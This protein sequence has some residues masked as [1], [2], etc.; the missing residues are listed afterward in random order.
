MSKRNN[1]PN[2]SNGQRYLT[3]SIRL[4]PEAAEGF[5][6]FCEANGCTRAGFFEATGQFMASVLTDPPD[7][8]SDGHEPGSPEWTFHL[9]NERGY[10]PDA[11]KAVARN[12]KRIDR[13]RRSRADVKR[14]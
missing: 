9:I 4:T 6:T 10:Q 5:D 14:R 2:E 13:E 12:A 11:L 7:G 1:A 3:W 8:A